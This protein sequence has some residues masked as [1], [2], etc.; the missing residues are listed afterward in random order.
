MI[1]TFN[2]ST[3]GKFSYK[4]GFHTST[5]HPVKINPTYDSKNLVTLH[6][7]WSYEN[8]GP[9]FREHLSEPKFSTDWTLDK[10]NSVLGVKDGRWRMEA[11][12]IPPTYV[13]LFPN[14]PMKI[15]WSS[16]LTFDQPHISPRKI[17][18][19]GQCPSRRK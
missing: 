1:R 4:K 18:V 3:D 16:L 19:A 15:G 14:I 6:P 2:I 17:Q 8:A 9:A 12:K 13:H 5:F 10:L 11:N 7:F